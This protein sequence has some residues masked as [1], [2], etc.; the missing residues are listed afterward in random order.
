MQVFLSVFTMD[1]KELND[2]NFFSI[3]PDNREEMGF[4]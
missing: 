2:D 3:D 1:I 4:G